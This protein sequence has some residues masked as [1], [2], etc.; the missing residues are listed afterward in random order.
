MTES[1]VRCFSM[2]GVAVAYVP[3]LIDLTIALDIFGKRE[4]GLGGGNVT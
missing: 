4:E 1:A 3:M 2:N